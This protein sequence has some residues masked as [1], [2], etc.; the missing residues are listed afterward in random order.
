M[1]LSTVQEIISLLTGLVGLISG[2]IGVYFAIKSF[3][4]S[5]KTK[6]EK[7]IWELIMTIADTAM[8]EVERTT[9]SGADKKEQ[10]MQIIKASC[11]SAGLEITPFIDQLSAYIDE[12]IKF[13]NKMQNKK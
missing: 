1:D 4:T 7:E 3:I 10:A 2:G 13:V 9:V 12:T 5:M 6:K 8:S 11:Q